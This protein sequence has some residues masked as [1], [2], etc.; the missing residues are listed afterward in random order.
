MQACQNIVH[1]FVTD[2]ARKAFID[3]RLQHLRLG[4]TLPV[5]TD[6]IAQ[7][8]SC[9]GIAASPCLF[10]DPFIKYGRQLDINLRHAMLHRI[11]V[12]I[13]HKMQE[14]THLVRLAS[15][16]LRPRTV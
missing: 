15:L 16:D 8:V 6:E 7:I 2:A 1:T 3:K 4:L 5:A 14:N 9:V 13:A 11:V 10:A 12:S